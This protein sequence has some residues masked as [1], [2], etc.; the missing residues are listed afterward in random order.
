[1][2]PKSKNRQRSF[3]AN[4]KRLQDSSLSWAS[5]FYKEVSWSHENIYPICWDYGTRTWSASW[6][7]DRQFPTLWGNL[8]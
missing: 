6:K 1:M 3:M 5:S 7:I 8:L 4:T 2:R